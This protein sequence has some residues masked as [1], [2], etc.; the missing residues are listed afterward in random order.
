MLC[1]LV[2]LKLLIGEDFS[3]YL[4]CVERTNC[5]GQICDS[6][7][8]G[9]FEII[10]YE[11]SKG[12]DIRFLD[13]GYVKNI[14]FGEV[15]SGKVAD[16]FKPSVYGIGILGDKYKTSYNSVVAKEYKLWRG[17]F[18]RCYSENIHKLRPRYADC[19]TSPNFNSYTY[20][21][22]WCNEQVGFNVD[23]FELDKDLLVKGNK[24]YSEDTCV[25]L[26]KE[27]N[28]V[29]EKSQKRRGDYPIGV[30]WHKA[31]KKFRAYI[32]KNG[33]SVHLGYFKDVESAFIVYK[34]A[35]ELHIKELAEKW[36][37]KIDDRAYNALMNYEVE[38]TD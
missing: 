21:Y 4:N 12:V 8:F 36:K 38:I 7:N 30:G 24:I 19:F 32:N 5:I 10:D 20:F 2:V 17:M 9:K 35:K 31:T 26:P 27:I 6:I 11:Y 22:E 3:M 18:N 14:K 28:I 13:T 29:L 33:E 23:G 16:K 34:M 37:G 1:L 25:F 15:R